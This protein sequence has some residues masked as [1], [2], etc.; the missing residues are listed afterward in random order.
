MPQ[1][2]SQGNRFGF[3]SMSMEEKRIVSFL[4]HRHGEPK[5]THSVSHAQEGEHR[6]ELVDLHL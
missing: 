4:Y 5:R 3:P 6:E 1:L 2:L